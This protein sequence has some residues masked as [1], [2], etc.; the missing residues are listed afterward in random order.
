MREAGELT[1]YLGGRAAFAGRDHDE[2]LHDCVI[3]GGTAGLDDEDI[4]LSDTVEDLDACLALQRRKHG[5][6]GHFAT[7][8][9]RGRGL[10]R[11]RGDGRRRA[12]DPAT[13]AGPTGTHIRELRE[14]RLCR[15]HAQALTYLACENRAG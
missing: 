4:F 1:G 6:P 15:R 7:E 3:D 10:S 2:Q 13:G 12:S 11:S 9:G 5:E 8:I 14:L